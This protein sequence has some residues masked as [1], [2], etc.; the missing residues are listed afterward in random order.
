M[1]NSPYYFGPP[2][3]GDPVYRLFDENALTHNSFYLL[4]DFNE[5]KNQRYGFSSATKQP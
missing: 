4:P 1:M 2:V 3:L 5:Q